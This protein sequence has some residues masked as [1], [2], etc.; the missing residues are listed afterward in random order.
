M[1]AT[2]CG[3]WWVITYFLKEDSRQSCLVWILCCGARF[4]RWGSFS[5]WKY[6]ETVSNVDK[7][8]WPGLLFSPE[9]TF[10]FSLYFLVFWKII[11]VPLFHF[12]LDAICSQIVFIASCGCQKF[13]TSTYC[14]F[15]K[16]N[17]HKFNS[18]YI[19][20]PL[21]QFIL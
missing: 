6:W 20:V 9:I 19:R 15:F 16:C 21:Y 8:T 13:H 3:T 17:V 11:Q 1:S 10:H 18:V 12:F 5:T 2:Y 7:R 14:S 4:L